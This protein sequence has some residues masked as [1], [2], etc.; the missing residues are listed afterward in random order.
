VAPS[1]TASA[2]PDAAVASELGEVES[3]SAEA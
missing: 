3:T 2:R 1:P